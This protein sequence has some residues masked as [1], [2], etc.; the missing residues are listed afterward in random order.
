MKIKLTAVLL[1]AFFLQ[2][3]ANGLAQNVT[4]SGENVPL[5][6]VF[7]VIKKQTGYFV[8]ANVEIIANTKPV[9]LTASN[10]PLNEFLKLALKNQPVGYIIEGKTIILSLKSTPPTPHIAP[11]ITDTAPKVTLVTII[12]KVL[13][14]KGAPVAGASIVLKNGSRGVNSNKDGNFIFP[15]IPQGGKLQIS[16]VGFESKEVEIKPG[17]NLI[18]ELKPSLLKLDDVVVTGMF[19]RRTESFTGAAQTYTKE[20]LQKVGNINVIQSLKNLDPSFYL[21][22]NLSAGSN[23]NVLPDI[24]LRGQSGFP[25]L[26]GEYQTNPNQPLFILDGFEVSITR[27]VDLDMNRVQSV[28]LLKDA[29]A[30]AIYGSK[31]ANGVVVIETQRPKP[32]KMLI[33]Y[34]ANVN[35]NAPDLSSYNLTNAAEKL[36]VEKAGGLYNSQGRN[37]IFFAD[38]Q[39]AYDQQYNKILEDVLKGVNTYW[40]SQ[41]LRTEI[42]QKHSLAAEGGSEQMRYLIDFSYNNVPGVMKGSERNNISGGVNLS[43]RA[44]KFQLRNAID[45]LFNKSNNSPYGSFSQ[46]ATMNPYFKP[47]DEDGNIT[48]VAGENI[49]LGNTLIGNPMWNATI[50]TKDLSRYSQVNE[51]FYADYY[52]SQFL[53]FTGRVGISKTESN[54]EVFY[55]ASHTLFVN[56]NTPDLLL[57]KGQYTYGDGNENRLNIDLLG[58]YARSFGNHIITANLGTNISS[59][60]RRNASFTAE[61]FPNDYLSDISFARQY[62]QNSRPSGSENTTR[63]IGVTSGLSYSFADRYFAEGTYRLSASSQFGKENRWGPF[64]SAGL[65]WNLHKEAFMRAFGFINQLKVRGSLG[66]TG[67]QNFNSY[68]S[69]ATFNYDAS[70]SYQ[71]NFG[72]FLLGLENESLKWQRK[73]DQNV[74]AEFVLFNRRVN[75]RFDYYVSNTTDLLTDVSVPLSTGFSSY[76]ENLGQIQNRGMEF[77]LSWSVWTDKKRSNSLSVFVGGARNE[78]RIKKIS[79]ALES[80]NKTQSNLPTT[81]PAV[82]YEEGQSLTAIWA[83][84]SNGIDPASGR[85]MLVKQDGTVTNIWNSND[86]RPIGDNEPT[87]RGNAGLNFDFNGFNINVSATYKFGGQIYNQTVVDKV[88]NADLRYN[89]DRRVFADRWKKPGDQTWFKDIADIKTTRATQRFVQDQDEWTLASVSA[90]YDL[91]RIRMIRRSGLT[92][93]RL[94]FLMNDPVFVSSVA[95]ERGTDYPFARSF[96]FTLNA[97]F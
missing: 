75:G 11:A 22:E 39:Y 61:G 8:F 89:V 13:D 59:I 15:S 10:M 18:I 33:T 27:I 45:V 4:F 9:T 76:K 67:S 6:K 68:L 88:E 96:S 95:L 7:K 25:D 44:K 71:G 24:Q 90:F 77:R 54:S 58:N 50:N 78:N 94:G 47:T 12:G 69:K 48:K 42:G 29:S 73:Y 3:T 53:R 43:Y 72:A 35:V 92:R 26:K 23:P 60:T 17:G 20:D 57:R 30:K 52:A 64:W 83:V 41:P 80:F 34:T 63:D 85:D 70:N 79:N 1:L 37:D 82:R 21:V 74:G 93:L 5:T 2:L 56:Y 55:P 65:G 84:P 14:A 97:M 31:A 16:S 32:G 66:Y 36:A 19:N 40:L 28:T 46:Y 81:K 38:Q 87:L 91:A 62:Q 86:L 49:I 51:N